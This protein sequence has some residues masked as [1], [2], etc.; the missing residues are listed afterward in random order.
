MNK[1][2]LEEGHSEIVINKSRF[3]GYIKQVNTEEEALEFIAEIKKKY[4]DARHNCMAYII[5]GEQEIKRF[6]DDGEPQGTAGKP[7]LDVLERQ[8]IKNAVIVVTRYFGGVLLGTGGLVRAYGSAAIEAV[9]DA[10]I[11]EEK[12]GVY[13]RIRTDYN[14]SGKI[15]YALHQYEGVEISTTYEDMVILE[16]CIDN[17]YDKVFADKI[18]EITSGNTGITDREEIKYAVCDG[19]FI[20]L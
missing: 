13:Y 10:K 19:E 6:S 17:E 2:V 18:T 20:K 3:L 11:C 15:V 1:D 8:S 14:L 12:E 16:L 7:I 4:W 9:K 5:G